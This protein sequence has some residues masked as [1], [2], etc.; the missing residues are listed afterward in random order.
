SA[1]AQI[2]G[3]ALQRNTLHQ[4]DE[5]DESAIT[6]ENAQH[7]RLLYQIREVLQR[8]NTLYHTVNA[9]V[10]L[11]RT[12]SAVTLSASIQPQH[13]DPACSTKAAICSKQC[14][15]CKNNQQKL[16]YLA[17]LMENIRIGQS[18]LNKLVSQ[19]EGGSD[20]HKVS[21][22][23]SNNTSTTQPATQRVAVRTSKTTVS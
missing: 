3:P 19:H 5:F 17:N 21:R 18:N 6:V 16:I 22:T 8:R 4:H 13:Q 2:L 1:V 7:L 12:S 20:V 9:M 14:E 10:D 23:S 15:N 11:P